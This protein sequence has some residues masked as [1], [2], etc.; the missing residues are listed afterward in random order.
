[1]LGGQARLHG[2]QRRLLNASRVQLQGGFGR[3]RTT[4]I[5]ICGDA[6]LGFVISRLTYI[7]LRVG[8]IGSCLFKVTILVLSLCGAITTSE[9]VGL[10]CLVHFQRVK[11]GVIFSIRFIVLDGH[12][13]YYCTNPRN[14]LRGSFIRGQGYSKRA[15]TGFTGIDIQLATRLNKATTRSFNL[16]NGLHISFGSRGCFP[17]RGT[18]PP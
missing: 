16:N 15:K 12:T 8:F 1:M 4:A 7:L 3:Q 2:V 9:R 10:Q 6:I 13:I 14:G 18:L 17:F 11:M 5:M